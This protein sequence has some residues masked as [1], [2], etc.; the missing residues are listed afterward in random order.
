MSGGEIMV[1]IR[2]V[3]YSCDTCLES[4]GHSCIFTDMSHERSIPE[5][6]PP[7]DCPYGGKADWKAIGPEKVSE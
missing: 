7:I 2:C 6:Q 1:S 5:T 4:H 3:G